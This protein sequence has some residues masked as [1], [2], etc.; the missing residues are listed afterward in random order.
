MFWNGQWYRQQPLSSVIGLRTAIIILERN[1]P[2]RKRPYDR[3]SCFNRLR[4]ALFISSD[5]HF[6]EPLW[7]SL[8]ATLRWC[9]N[10]VSGLSASSCLPFANLL[11]LNMRR[12]KQQLYYLRVMSLLYKSVWMKIKETTRR[13]VFKISLS[14]FHLIN[15]PRLTMAVIALSSIPRFH[16]VS[17]RGE[18]IQKSL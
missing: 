17:R 11:L 6:I 8:W 2:W 10:C 16:A 1:K 4:T 14:I 9:C 5:V 13:Y 18:S 3:L 7:T 15:L 12:L